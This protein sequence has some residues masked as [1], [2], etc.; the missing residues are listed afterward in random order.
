MKKDIN[1]FFTNDKIYS[2]IDGRT[3]ANEDKLFIARMANDK[4][5]ASLIED[6]MDATCFIHEPNKAEGEYSVDYSRTAIAAFCDNN[7]EDIKSTSKVTTTD[8]LT[9]QKAKNL[10][11]D[12]LNSLEEDN[13]DYK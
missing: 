2:F 13:P 11:D 5:F 4:D 3:T 8:I 9:S 12:F 1:S 6:L 10:T 7:V